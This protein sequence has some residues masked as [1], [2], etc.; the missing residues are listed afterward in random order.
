MAELNGRVKEAYREAFEWYDRDRRKLP[1]IHIT[2]YP[3]IGVN[4]TIRVRN[5]EV[6]VRIAEICEDMP[7]RAHRGLAM[8]LVGKLYRRKV[9]KEFETDYTDY[10]NSADVRRRATLRRRSRGRKVVTSSKGEVYD[11]DEIFDQLNRSYFWPRLPKPV[12][13]WSARKTYRI[14]GH[15]DA[16]HDHI[17][18]S[19]SLDSRDVPRFVVEYVVFHEMLH[20]AHPTR[21]I[22]GRR[23]NHT[24]AF[25][26]DEEK[27]THY[28]R[29]ETWIERNVTRLKRAARRG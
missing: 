6:F 24:P 13:T 26:A 10:A 21:H 16:Q 7:L 28:H 25:R 18:I 23:H 14:L 20:I 22:N 8:I 3:Y 2:H 27:F 4:H 15:H 19:R 12:L 29:A 5:G 17:A 11:L 1:D 9:P